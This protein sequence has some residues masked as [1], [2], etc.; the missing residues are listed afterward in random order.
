[1]K[2]TSMKLA[3]TA[4]TAITH[5]HGG[6]FPSPFFKRF[7]FLKPIAM[8]SLLLAGAA[9]YAQAVPF[10][11][12]G[13]ITGVDP[14]TRTISVMGLVV[15]V[16][17]NTAISSPTAKV[18]M[19]DLVGDPLPG[20]SERGFIG[21][22]AIATGTVQ[23]DGTY[24]ASE[25]KVDP[26][27]NMLRGPIVSANPARMGRNGLGRGLELRPILDPRVPAGP[28][29][30][31]Y[32]FAVKLGSLLP[33]TYAAAGAYYSSNDDILY[34]HTL[35]I[36]GDAE[37]V[38][39]GNQVSIQRAH[40][41]LRGRGRDEFQ[42]RGGVTNGT[43]APIAVGTQVT[44]TLAQA[45]GSRTVS[46]NVIPAAEAPGFGTYDIKVGNLTFPTDGCPA[47]VTANSRLGT[48]TQATS[49]PA[50]VTVTGL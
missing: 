44:F 12:E 11:I 40:C 10:E 3:A 34:F 41:R 25:V 8:A 17:L 46:V 31:E 39:A 27:E 21:G 7:S 33:G 18:N 50:S 19:G 49:D 43:R 13:P 14:V 29:N 32:G 6:G 24:L 45:V 30:N 5:D 16:P 47:S 15:A 22:T 1:M 48:V 9:A 2:H 26:A 36:T 4:L 23:A 42:I 28:V 38:K 20:R 35:E 37:L